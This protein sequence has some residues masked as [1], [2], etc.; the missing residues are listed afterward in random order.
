MIKVSG[1]RIS[2]TEIEEAALASGAAAEA[3]AIGVPDERL[4]QAIRLIVRG[5]GDEAALRG[6]LRTEL[7]SFQQPREIVWVE[8]LPRSPNGK[9]D[10]V[11]V[12]R[13]HGA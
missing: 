6:W 12:A 3:V 13:K 11:A 1:H 5:T 9:I 10:R 8:A 2:P 4:G 7:P